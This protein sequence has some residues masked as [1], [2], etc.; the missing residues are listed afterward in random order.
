M[1][2]KTAH[3]MQRFRSGVSASAVPSNGLRCLSSD[4]VVVK[5]CGV[6]RGE[7]EQS[8][9]NSFLSSFN[10]GS[11]LLQP[12]QLSASIALLQ[13]LVQGPFLSSECTPRDEARFMGINQRV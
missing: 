7:E 9:G 11:V 12:G 8:G 5:T 6:L 10:T 1:S 2:S 13:E 4:G 3:K